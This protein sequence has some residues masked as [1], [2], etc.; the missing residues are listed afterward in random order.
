MPRRRLPSR[1]T[2]LVAALVGTALLALAACNEGLP[3]T[4]TGPLILEPG[5]PI[6][7]SDATNSQRTY[8]LTVPE[9]TGKLRILLSGFTGD[10]DVYMRFG[11]APEPGQLDC[12]SESGFNVEEC[13]I[14][15]PEAG[16]WYILI[17]GY[18]AFSDADLQADFFAQV[19][20]RP[21][22]DGVATTGINGESGDF[23]M[24]AITLPAGVDSLVVELA[25]TGDADLYLGFDRLPLLNSYECASFTETSAERCLVVTPPAGRWVVRVDSYLAFS[26][27]SLTARLYAPAPPPAAQQP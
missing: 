20:E 25:G 7:I 1:P 16:T 27:G 17:Y 22:A 5:T 23:E 24:F 19:G 21:L 6:T 13:I 4:P 12:A 11:A 2:N 18:S 3:T 15:A 9:G 14:E 8:Q 26:D 10:A